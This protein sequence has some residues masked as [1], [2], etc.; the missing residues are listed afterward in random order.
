MTSTKRLFR[1]GVVACVL[2]AVAACANLLGIED[3]RPRAPDGGAEAGSDTANLVDAPPDGRVTFEPAVVLRSTKQPREVAVDDKAVY[4]VSSAATDAGP[5]GAIMRLPFAGG[6]PAELQRDA[7]NLIGL[8]IDNQSVIWAADSGGTHVYRASKTT[9]GSPVDIFHRQYTSRAAPAVSAESGQVAFLFAEKSDAGIDETAVRFEPVEGLKSGTIVAQF[10]GA[11]PSDVA[12]HGNWVYWGLS[13]GVH[14][15]EAKAG[16]TPTVWAAGDAVARVARAQQ[17]LV[18]ATQSGKLL[19][20]RYD[21]SG[22]VRTLAEGVGSVKGLS[23]DDT[24]AYVASSSGLVLAVPLVGGPIV[25]LARATSPFG[26][27][28]GPG[29]V[30]FT[31]EAAETL[32]RV[33]K[34][35]AAR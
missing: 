30:Y 33:A 8:A 29:A 22:D 13:G 19:A 2:L 35:V 18:W 32:N 20:K 31:D 5:T 34:R 1:S 26:V 17:D 12:L 25:E 14:R 6:D 16:Q 23:V 21:S 4:W 28:A 7:L 9:A 11:V 27:A 24:H 15:A 10:P 3:V